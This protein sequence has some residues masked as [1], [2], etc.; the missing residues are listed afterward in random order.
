MLTGTVQRN[1]TSVVHG[2]SHRGGSFEG[3][4][5]A[6]RRRTMLDGQGTNGQVQQTKRL[7]NSSVYM[8]T[9]TVTR[10]LPVAQSKTRKGSEGGQ[11]AFPV[12]DVPLRVL[13]S[14]GGCMANN[15]V[16]LLAVQPSKT[17]GIEYSGRLIRPHQGPC[18]A[19][20]YCRCGVSRSLL[21][22]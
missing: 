18:A 19:P 7:I 9:A 22:L 15:L 1:A 11:S 6:V 8:Y 20:S 17:R 3:P 21:L 2:N 12:A 14:Y 4:G 5:I 16:K 13:S 10:Y